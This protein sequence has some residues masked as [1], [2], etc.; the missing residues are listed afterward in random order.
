[1]KG[2]ALIGRLKQF[3]RVATRYDKTYLGGRRHMITSTSLGGER[4]TAGTVKTLPCV[5][6][7]PGRDK[8]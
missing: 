4:G 8:G 6:P 7:V 2:P 1:M 5:L 3:R